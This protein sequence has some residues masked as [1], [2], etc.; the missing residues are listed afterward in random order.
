MKKKKKVYLRLGLGNI[1]DSP[2]HAANKNHAALG[3]AL[4]QMAGDGGSE[5][6]GAV[7]VDGE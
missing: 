7:N 3:L 4:H 5:E 2:A 1:D 6:V